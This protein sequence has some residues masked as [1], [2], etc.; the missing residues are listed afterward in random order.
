[1]LDSMVNMMVIMHSVSNIT[2]K[3]NL[4]LKKNYFLMQLWWYLNCTKIPRGEFYSVI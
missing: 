1:M 4:V 3:E 2:V